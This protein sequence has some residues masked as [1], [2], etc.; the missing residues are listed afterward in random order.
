MNDFYYAGNC[1]GLEAE[2]IEA[3]VDARQSISYA[4]IT[5]RVCKSDLRDFKRRRGYVVG[6]NLT[7][8]NAYAVRFYKSMFKGKL[9]YYIEHNRIEYIFLRDEE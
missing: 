2:D 5:R 1:K 4:T 3:M 6:D 9:C 8:E 7:L